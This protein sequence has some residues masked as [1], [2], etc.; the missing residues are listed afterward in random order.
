MSPLLLRL[1]VIAAALGIWFWSQR[2]IGGKAGA[3]RIITDGIHHLTRGW[4]RYL[5]GKPRLA[6][7]MLIVSSLLIDMM[8]LGLIALSIFGTTFAPFLGVVIVFSLRHLAQLCCTLPPPAGMIW[9]DPGFPSVLVTYKVSNDLFFSGHTSLACLAAIEAC[10]IGPWWLGLTVLVV[11]T[12]EAVLVLVLRAHYT[13]DVVCGIF[14][15]W[16]ASDLALRIAPHIDGL[17]R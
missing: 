10:R 11:A 5:A 2:L 6:D 7:R 4:H 3:G 13:M 16:F 15:A 9:R 8:G 12:G 17:L 1:L 14:A